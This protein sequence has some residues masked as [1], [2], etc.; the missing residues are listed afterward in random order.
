MNCEQYRKA[1]T[2]DPSENFDG[3]MA[4]A[5]GCELCS[6]Y[7]ADLRSLDERIACALSIE[8]PALKMP[9]LPPAHEVANKVTDL[10]QPGF[11]RRF[12]PAPP[13]W[14]GLAAS[15]IMVAILV[16]SFPGSERAPSLAEEIIAHMDHEQDSRGVTSVPV[17][18]R[19]LG[20]VV[21]PDVAAM[22][23]S[24]GLITYAMSCIINGRTVPHLVVQG[25][26]GPVT[27]I[28]LP[29]ETISASIPLSGENVYGVILPVGSG[30][31]A[32]IGQREEQQS[33]IARIGRKI[34]DSVEW[35]I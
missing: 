27:L 8:V 9:V 28:L 14:A 26:G 20:E 24:I 29:E 21:G 7:R 32:V 6:R 17:S 23:D 18:M 10:P 30:S 15:L 13:L 3:G 16:V 34:A 5:A 33:E 31:V 4:H 1:I 11:A 12:M 35:T 25:T 19:T 22:D 2:A